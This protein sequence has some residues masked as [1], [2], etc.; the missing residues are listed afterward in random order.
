M[1]RSHAA[2]SAANQYYFFKIHE[3]VYSQIVFFSE[4]LYLCLRQEFLELQFDS[5]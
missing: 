1:H 2:I 5:H 3:V 4:N